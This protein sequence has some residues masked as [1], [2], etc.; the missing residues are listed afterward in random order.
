MADCLDKFGFELVHKNATAPAAKVERKVV[1]I[2]VSPATHGQPLTVLALCCDG[3]VLFSETD[4]SEA[5]KWH[6][7]APIPQPEDSAP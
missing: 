2:V 6:T 3:A 1:Q 7:F 4:G 5:F